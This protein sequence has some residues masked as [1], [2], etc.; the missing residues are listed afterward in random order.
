MQRRKNRYIRNEQ[1]RQ[2]TIAN[3]TLHHTTQRCIRNYG[4]VANPNLPIQKNFNNTLEK[5]VPNNI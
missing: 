4:F 2:R 5:E 1:K 3:Q